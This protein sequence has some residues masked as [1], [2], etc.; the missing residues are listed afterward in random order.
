VDV[1]I[2]GF[3]VAV[4]SVTINDVPM[5]VIGASSSTSGSQRVESWVLAGATTGTIAVNL[6][7]T[8]DGA[9]GTAVS[10]VGVDQS[11]PVEAIT[12]GYGGGLP[13]QITVTPLSANTWVRAALTTDLTSPLAATN[14]GRNNVVGELGTGAN[15]DSNAGTPVAIGY[16]ADTDGLWA[17]VGYAIRPFVPTPPPPAPVQSR[18][19]IGIGIGL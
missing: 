14:M 4:E 6:T 8:A 17:M 18:L 7:G 16:D 9:L 2:F 5:M 11:S 12:A 1:H 19:S 15:E 13:I 10:Y 3:G